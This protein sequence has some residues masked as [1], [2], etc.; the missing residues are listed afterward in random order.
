MVDAPE[1]AF[2]API[3]GESLT[4]E[5]G[6][7][8]WQQPPQYSTIE[9]ALNEFYVPRIFNPD[10]LGELLAVIEMGVPLT[11]IANALQQGA[12]MQGVHSIDLGILAL[13]VI[14]ECLAYVA[15]EQDVEY[16]TGMEGDK[17]I[18]PSQAIMA[19]AKKELDE[20]EGPIEPEDQEEIEEPVEEPE[21]MQTGLMA[22]RM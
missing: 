20:K 10:T 19:L 18:E 3:A 4:S 22:R 21:E 6:S 7:F 9:E 1:I 8:P 15:E 14:M 2:N 17:E 5:L 12:V 16:N 11:T 13:P